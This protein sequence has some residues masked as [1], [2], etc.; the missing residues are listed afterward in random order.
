MASLLLFERPEK[1]ES[2]AW[3][4]DITALTNPLAIALYSNNSARVAVT[5]SLQKCDGYF[6][7]KCG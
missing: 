7:T 1:L 5:I 6:N 2:L 4:E 3:I